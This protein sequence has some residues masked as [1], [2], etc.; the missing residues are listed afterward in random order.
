MSPA[1]E[2]IEDFDI[3]AARLYKEKTVSFENGGI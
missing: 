3:H 2:G 1:G